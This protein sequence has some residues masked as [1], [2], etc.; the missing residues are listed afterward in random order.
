VIGGHDMAVRTM[1]SPVRSS[2]VRGVL[3]QLGGNAA[4][5]RGRASIAKLA[6]RQVGV[7][8]TPASTDFGSNCDPYTTFDGVGASSAG[9][10]V[11]PGSGVLTENEEWCS[12]FAK[13]VWAR[14]RGQ[15]PAFDAGRPR[16]GDAV[17]FYP[18]FVSIPDAT[19]ADHVGIVAGVNVNGTLNL[20]NGDFLGATNITVQLNTDVSLAP[21]GAAIWGSGEKWL[22]VAPVFG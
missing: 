4:G 20:V 19:N 22:L 6:V 12:D 18:S 10:G 13:W 5:L 7:G 8:D 15:S 11:D 3:R 17:L 16:V 9:C 14:Q 2:G 21:W 1:L